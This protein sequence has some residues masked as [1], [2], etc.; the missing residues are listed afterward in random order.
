MPGRVTA[1]SPPTAAPATTPTATESTQ[2]QPQGKPWPGLGKR[3]DVLHL[4][5]IEQGVRDLSI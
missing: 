2:S 5:D 1:N 4:E 3:V